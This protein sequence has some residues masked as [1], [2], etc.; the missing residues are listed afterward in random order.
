M[1]QWLKKRIEKA[2]PD[3]VETISVMVNISAT[4][5]VC[6]NVIEFLEGAELPDE[7][8]DVD[9]D[10][11]QVTAKYH[12]RPVPCDKCLASATE[13][14]TVNGFEQARAILDGDE[15]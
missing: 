15:F 12:L 1:F 5:A 8:V 9:K 13:R 6:G 7:V 2:V 3:T 11:T 10:Q 4:C 14:A